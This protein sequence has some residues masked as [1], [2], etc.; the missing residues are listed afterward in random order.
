MSQTEMPLYPK[1]SSIYNKI[2][3]LALAIVFIVVLMNIWIAS[4]AKFNG[5]IKQHLN[6]IAQDYTQNAANTI[7]I[8]IKR[9]NSNN[10][11][12]KNYIQTLSQA[13]FIEGARF[14][15]ATGQ[16]ILA[17]DSSTTINELYGNANYKINRSDKYIPFVSE[18][19]T[20]KL[21][22]YIRLTINRPF[23]TQQLVQ[24]NQD[25]RQL[26]RLMLLMAGVIGFLLTRGLNRF[27][28][29]GFRLN[30]HRR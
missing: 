22:G 15:D 3:Q 1:I 6:I 16:L 14:Y 26:E 20:D 11:L 12:L 25:K 29:R 2:T 7:K 4:D 18:I 5:L 19:R 17:S 21:Q 24:N 13:K 30:P 8:L 23:L 10:Q 28:R 9:K 27:S